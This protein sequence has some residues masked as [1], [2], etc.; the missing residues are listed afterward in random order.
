M[1]FDEWMFSRAVSTP[2]LILLR[3][4]SWDLGTITFGYN[5]RAESAFDH[6][7]LGTTPVIRRITGGRALYHDPSELTY[8]IAI[9]DALV[10]Y[11]LFGESV[12]KTSE[13]IAKILVQ[14]LKKCG[15]DSDYK[16][17]SSKQDREL[18]FFHKAPCFASN[19]KNEIVKDNIKIIAS[20]QRRFKGSIFQHGSIKV[21]GHA[22]HP[23]L[24]LTDYNIN[25]N[26]KLNVLSKNMF[27]NFSTQFNDTFA[28][29]LNLNFNNLTIS[30]EDTVEINSI[31]EYVKQN[32]MKKRNIQKFPVEPA[33]I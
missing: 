2:A 27:D 1:A 17:R 18:D 25:F 23:A 4:Y 32:H 8:S 6:D 31:C 5:Q 33:I 9:N 16:K 30:A 10:K 24:P 29:E 21:N 11:S 26:N 14:F 13:I 12:S 28:E 19:S 22:T 20:A 15:I 3:L 7:H